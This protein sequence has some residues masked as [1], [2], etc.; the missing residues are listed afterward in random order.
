METIF[1]RFW[2]QK[3][4]IFLWAVLLAVPPVFI[5]SQALFSPDIPFLWPDSSAA[6]IRYPSPLSGFSRN[7]MEQG[8]FQ[9]DIFIQNEGEQIF[10]SI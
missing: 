5:L 1:K 8:E 4:S 10:T 2:R 9:K 7:Y 6:W 3:R